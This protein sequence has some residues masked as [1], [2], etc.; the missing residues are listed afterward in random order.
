[1]QQFLE[2]KASFSRRTTAVLQFEGRH[3]NNEVN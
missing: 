1:M 3:V 2:K